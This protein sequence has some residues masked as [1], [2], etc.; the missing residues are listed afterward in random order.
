M[1]EVIVVVAELTE[2]LIT[3]EWVPVAE[4]QPVTVTVSEYTPDIA[5]WAFVR[6]GFCRLEEYPEGPCQR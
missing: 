1:G 4:P 5:S 6:E 3:T 2:G